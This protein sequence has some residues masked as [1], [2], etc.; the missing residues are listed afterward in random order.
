MAVKG[1]LGWWFLESPSQKLSFEG[2]I[3]S[4][5]SLDGEL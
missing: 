3:K 1:S 5:G 4:I 2:S